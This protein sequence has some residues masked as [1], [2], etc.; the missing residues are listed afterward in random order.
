[1]DKRDKIHS[2]QTSRET[3][4][5]RNLDFSKLDQDDTLKGLIDG[6]PESL[7]RIASEII[8][9]HSSNEDLLSNRLLKK[10]Q[11]SSENEIVQLL[12]ATSYREEFL[13]KLLIVQIINGEEADEL[14]NM[15]PVQT[16]KLFQYVGQKIGDIRINGKNDLQKHQF[17]NCIRVIFELLKHEFELR[18]P[19]GGNAKIRKIM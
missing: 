16:L 19:G 3:V 18:V 9:K 8:V 5:F 4:E 11:N 13:E 7:I 17:L 10:I 2:L 6:D 12:L 15:N 1:M 14:R